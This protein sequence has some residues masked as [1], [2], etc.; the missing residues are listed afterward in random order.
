ME[1]YI[2]LYFISYNS[3]FTKYSAAE[4][5]NPQELPMDVLQQNI[6]NGTEGERNSE[7]TVDF[8]KTFNPFTP[9]LIMQILPTIQEENDWVV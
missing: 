1:N 5:N 2:S 4:S 9:K 7:R 8:T 6:N 3:T